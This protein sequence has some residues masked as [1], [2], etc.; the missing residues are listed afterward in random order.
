M[1]LNC[2][3]VIY[4]KKLIFFAHNAEFLIRSRID[5]NMCLTICRVGIKVSANRYRTLAL[6]VQE[7]RKRG[8][9]VGNN[10]ESSITAIVVAHPASF[11]VCC[12]LGCTVAE[13]EVMATADAVNSIGFV[14][15][16]Q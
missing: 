12:I 14:T 5:S 1:Y 6:T 8:F 15:M 7:Y 10:G 11:V 13:R 16:T 9:R 3:K 4:L 2:K